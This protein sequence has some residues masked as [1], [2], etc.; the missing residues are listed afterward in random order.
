MRV[1]CRSGANEDCPCAFPLAQSRTDRRREQFPAW[2]PLARL[3]ADHK[4][5]APAVRPAIV[6]ASNAKPRLRPPVLN[7]GQVLLVADAI[8]LRL[9]H[10]FEGRSHRFEGQ[11]RLCE[12]ARDHD[13][14]A[15]VAMQC[16]VRPNRIECEC[17]SESGFT[18]APGETQSRAHDARLRRR[19]EGN[20]ADTAGTG[21]ATRSGRRLRPARTQDSLST[22]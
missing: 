17:R 22:T 9:A 6:R 2:P 18:A 7:V 15:A 4:I 14:L 21:T 13:S 19:R 10:Q 1:A 5:D 8:V 12:R 16:P 11:A 3:V 20:A